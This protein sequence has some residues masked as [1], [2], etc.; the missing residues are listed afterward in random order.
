MKRYLMEKSN[1]CV[2]VWY[3]HYIYSAELHESG[4]TNILVLQK[5]K[6]NLLQL[7]VIPRVAQ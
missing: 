1:V 6:L 5:T 3:I 4:I 7:T 2:C